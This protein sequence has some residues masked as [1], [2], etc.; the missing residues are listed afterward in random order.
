[1]VEWKKPFACFCCAAIFPLGR[2]CRNC[3][4]VQ[5]QFFCE[6]DIRILNDG[7]RT[8]ID[9]LF[10]CICDLDDG[11]FYESTPYFLGVE[12]EDLFRWA[13]LFCNS[14]NILMFK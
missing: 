10:I 11:V 12:T 2:Q 4:Q 1:M 7:L 13:E 8:A 14:L 9:E 5:Q 6:I 3:E